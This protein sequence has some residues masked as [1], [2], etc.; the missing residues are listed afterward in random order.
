MGGKRPPKRTNAVKT[1]PQWLDFTAEFEIGVG[2]LELK[3]SEF[4]QLTPAEF[5]YM[6][7]GYKRNQKRH[8]NEVLIGAWHTAALSRMEKMPSLNSLLYDDEPKHEQTED[9]MYAMCKMLNA[10]FGGVE[11]EA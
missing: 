11:V 10:A 4:W 1:E 2:E 3:P 7:D 8:I 9:E 5:Y 6:L